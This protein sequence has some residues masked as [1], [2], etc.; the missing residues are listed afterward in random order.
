MLD[1]KKIREEQPKVEA[2]LEKRM[3]KVSLDK[4]VELDTKRLKIRKEL[5]K[6]QELRNKTSKLIPLM[7]KKVRMFLNK[8]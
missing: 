4:I 5:E 8:Y 7:K 1:I 6:M 3:G 2:A